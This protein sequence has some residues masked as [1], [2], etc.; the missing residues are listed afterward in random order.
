MIFVPPEHLTTE[1]ARAVYCAWN[2]YATAVSLFA[3]ALYRSGDWDGANEA[4]AIYRDVVAMA[5]KKLARMHEQNGFEHDE[6][7]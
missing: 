6:R 4:L 2:D 5:Q 7:T 1:R 3:C